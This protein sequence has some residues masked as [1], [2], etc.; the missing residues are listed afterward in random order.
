MA[1]TRNLTCSGTARKESKMSTPIQRLIRG[2]YRVKVGGRRSWNVRVVFASVTLL[3]EI[4]TILFHGWP[5]VSG[6]QYLKG[7]GLSSNMASTNSLS[8]FGYNVFGPIVRNAFEKRHWETSFV[9]IF[10]NH[11]VLAG[12]S[13]QFLFLCYLSQVVR[14]LV[15]RWYLPSNN[16]TQ[17][18]SRDLV[19]S[20]CWAKVSVLD[21]PNGCFLV[22]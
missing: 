2:D 5:I 9:K 21:W 6:S 19:C 8:H 16:S 20:W 17:F 13:Y 7:E 18:V 1:T 22:S 14:P 10:S 15:K 11:C 4:S 12:I 3:D